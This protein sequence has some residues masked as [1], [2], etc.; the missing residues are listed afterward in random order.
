MDPDSPNSFDVL[1]FR[2]FIG[3]R[4][5]SLEWGPFNEH[6]QMALSFSVWFDLQAKELDQLGSLKL[7]DN[8]VNWQFVG[9]VFTN[10]RIAFSGNPS[11]W[12]GEANVFV[13]RKILPSAFHRMVLNIEK[14]FQI[15]ASNK[16][17]LFDSKW[18]D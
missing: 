1:Q 9:C 8:N 3:F 2:V 14:W 12:I 18:R 10:L 16:R 6:S 7:D 11:L 13:W 4:F 15:G 17:I 5:E